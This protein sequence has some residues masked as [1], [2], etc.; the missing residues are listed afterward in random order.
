M[1]IDTLLAMDTIEGIDDQ[2]MAPIVFSIPEGPMRLFVLNK[3]YNSELHSSKSIGYC[4]DL[5]GD[6]ILW[7][8]DSLFLIDQPS[9]QQGI[10]FKDQIIINGFSSVISLNMYSGAQN[11]RG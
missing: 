1:K 4:Y 7:R 3:Q 9:L 6:S 10:I 5:K 8:Q 11:W 2:F